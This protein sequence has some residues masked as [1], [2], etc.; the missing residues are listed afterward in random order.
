MNQTYMTKNE[1]EAV[2]QALFGGAARTLEY[3]GIATVVFS[4]MENAEM[5]WKD[6]GHIRIM[7]EDADF[8]TQGRQ[9]CISSGEERI[10]YS[11]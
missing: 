10:I 7:Q 3:D 1:K 4:S 11:Y 8:L 6:P 9:M 2:N 5:Y